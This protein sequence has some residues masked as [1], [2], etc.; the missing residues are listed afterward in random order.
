MIRIYLIFLIG[1][2]VSSCAKTTGDGSN[3]SALDNIHINSNSPVQIG[4]TI[5]FAVPE[6]GGYRIYTWHG[7]NNYSGQEP[8]D[9]ITYA[10]LKQE[11]WYY[12]N[13]SKPD[14]NS[15]ID[16][17]YIDVKLNQGTPSCT[18]SSNTCTYSN[19]FNDTYNS[20]HKSIDPSYNVLT[21]SA[22]G[23]SNMKVLF[24]PR[25][26]TVE[27][28]DG[29][30]NTI[31]V[32]VFDPVDANYNKVFISTVK[33]SIYWASHPD[34]KVYVSHVNNKLQVRFCSFAMS[35]SNGTSYTTSVSGNLNEQ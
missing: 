24:H 19:L 10:E 7:P 13:I 35:G 18:I 30:Y 6:V 25:W 17:V 15:W 14:C 8:A 29:I 3:C 26:N 16:S 1:F 32:P 23:T 21:L 27:P 33:Q 9:S 34:Q 11:G 4:Q 31:N 5:K 22:D 28:E 2:F 12:L 20:I